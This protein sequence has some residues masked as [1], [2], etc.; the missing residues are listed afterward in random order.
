MQCPLKPL[1]QAEG[2]TEA[3]LYLLLQAALSDGSPERRKK[4]RICVLQRDKLLGPAGAT[5]E[6]LRTSVTNCI[7]AFLT[8]HL[9][10]LY[11]C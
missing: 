10:S 3:D 11:P 6:A 5:I 1:Q 4:I 8:T 7:E 9:P 2:V